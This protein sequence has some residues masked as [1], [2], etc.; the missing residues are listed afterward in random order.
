[1]HNSLDLVA[2]RLTRKDSN[3]ESE[4]ETSSIASSSENDDANEELTLEDHKIANAFA[5]SAQFRNKTKS[6]TGLL[7]LAVSIGAGT[8][9]VFASSLTKR[10]FLHPLLSRQDGI[11]RSGRLEEVIELARA[12]RGENIHAVDQDWPRFLASVNIANLISSFDRCNRYESR[13]REW[14][15]DLRKEILMFHGNPSVDFPVGSLFAIKGA[16]AYAEHGHEQDGIL[17]A[18]VGYLGRSDSSFKHGHD[19]FAVVKYKITGSANNFLEWDKPEAVLAQV[20]CWLAG[21]ETTRISLVLCEIGFKLVYRIKVGVHPDCRPI[22]NY[23]LF[24]PN[25]PN[26]GKSGYLPCRSSGFNHYANMESLVRV[27][28]ESTKTSIHGA[29]LDSTIDA[30]ARSVY[31]VDEQ[32]GVEDLN[33]ENSEVKFQVQK[34]VNLVSSVRLGKCTTKSSRTVSNNVPSPGCIEL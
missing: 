31:A 27:I 28:Y 12:Q 21:E 22:F 13:L 14:L 20:M 2:M 34:E 29:T 24:P 32:D 15:T 5:L 7:S 25:N 6:E 10:S 8:R 16:L 11:F 19:T 30:K 33:E 23:Y 1:M 4:R 3:W 9:H 17:D 26:T 18:T